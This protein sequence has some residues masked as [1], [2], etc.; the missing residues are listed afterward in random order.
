MTTFAKITFELNVVY[1][2]ELDTILL[3]SHAIVVSDDCA[4]WMKALEF[5]GSLVSFKID[6]GAD[7]TVVS[8]ATYYSLIKR[9]PLMVNKAVLLSTVLL[10]RLSVAGSFIR[11]ILEDGEQYK[12]NVL[13]F[14]TALKNN[15]LYGSVSHKLGLVS[16]GRIQCTFH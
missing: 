1:I 10:T 13:V 5:C 7:I 6:T 14:D 4:P 3:D 9:S 16:L 11:D 2:S 12:F 15:L 8:K